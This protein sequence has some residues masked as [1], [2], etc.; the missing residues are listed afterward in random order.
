MLPTGQGM[1][2]AIPAQT[3][4]PPHTEEDISTS[5]KISSVTI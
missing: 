5:R 4:P 2:S 1:N 3:T